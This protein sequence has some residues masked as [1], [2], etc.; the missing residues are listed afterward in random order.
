MRNHNRKFREIKKDVSFILHHLKGLKG[1]VVNR[2]CPALDGGSLLH[3]YSTSKSELVPNY[4]GVDPRLTSLSLSIS[5]MFSWF[6]SPKI[7]SLG[8][9]DMPVQVN[10]VPNRIMRLKYLCATVPL[11]GL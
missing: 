4:T 2:T 6:L 3:L 8:T 1:N 11:K 9:K 5:K 10:I 7:N